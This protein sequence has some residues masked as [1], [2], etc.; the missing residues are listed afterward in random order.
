MFL[1]GAAMVLSSACT[2]P[3]QVWV[4]MA[5][6]QVYASDSDAESKVLFTLPVGEACAR[7]QE[8]VQKVYLHTEVQCK[9]G[10]G[11]VIDNQNFE[12]GAIAI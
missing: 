3:P 10:R 8:R 9:S 1:T 5:P 12:P 4:V 11:W 6:T 2:P 7:L